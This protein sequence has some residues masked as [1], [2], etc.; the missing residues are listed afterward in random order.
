ME[1]MKEPN[2][3]HQ[4][5]FNQDQTITKYCS[6][7]EAMIYQEILNKSNAKYEKEN[8]ILRE[9]LPKIVK[10]ET[11]KEKPYIVLENIEKD[12][13]KDYS[14][15]ILKMGSKT[16]APTDDEVTKNICN[17]ID[18]K[19]TSAKYGFRIISYEINRVNGNSEMKISRNLDDYSKI[20]HDHIPI[21][22]KLFLSTKNKDV[23]NKDATLYFEAFATKLMTFFEKVNTR[24]FINSDIYFGYSKEEN[25]FVAKIIDLNKVFDISQLNLNVQKDENYLIGITKLFQI[26]KDLLRKACSPEKVEMAGGHVDNFK[27]NED[28]TI[29]KMTKK[30]EMLFIK[31]L[32][33]SNPSYKYFKENE[34][35][36]RFM[37]KYYK[38]YEKEG[39]PYLQMENLVFG[40]THASI[41]DIRLGSRLYGPDYPESKKLRHIADPNGYTSTAIGFRITGFNIKD[42]KGGS[43]Y[44]SYKKAFSPQVIPD[45]IEKFLKSN[46]K[47]SINTEA[48][49]FYMS[50]CKEIYDFFDKISTRCF[51]AMSLFF[52]I[53]NIDNR[54][55]M[56]LIDF[57][58]SY[59][60][61][62]FQQQKDEC[63]LFGLKNL[64]DIFNKLSH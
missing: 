36:K 39:K 23:I 29:D 42:E 49:K 62:T 61:E 50:E 59:P 22:F 63:I 17:E 12:F 32:L 41:L 1:S 37:P 8:E 13:N 14:Y 24:I 58:H 11:D 48:L 35:M 57:S 16:F 26:V 5:I 64:M 40:M 21:L 33:E 55:K 60:V 18:L 51:I 25:K 53:S 52:T 38:V 19:T 15:L 9:F 3:E 20:N 30:T 45:I 28:G 10:V 34:E 44:K 31:N 46:N 47:N 2:H 7:K 56:K 4:I 54:F 6:A 43:A 27:F